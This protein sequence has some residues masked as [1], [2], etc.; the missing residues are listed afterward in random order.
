[1][2]VT[3]DMREANPATRPTHSDLSDKAQKVAPDA[4]WSRI[5]SWITHRWGVREVV[6]VVEG[7][8]EWSARLTPATITAT[9]IWTGGGW[10]VL[11]LPPSPFGLLLPYIGPYR[12]TTTTGEAGDPPDAVMEAFRRLAEFSAGARTTITPGWEQYSIGGNLSVKQRRPGWQ[13]RALDGSG[14]ADLLR[15]WRSL[16]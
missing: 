7:P 5:E 10:E 16:A 3:L 14:A 8:G 1:M 13:A 6:Y 9:E 4:I 11:E 15:P 2:A 12:I